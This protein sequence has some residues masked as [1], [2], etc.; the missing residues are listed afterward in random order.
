WAHPNHRYAP[1]R[2]TLEAVARAELGLSQP[3]LLQQLAPAA[4]GCATVE[5]L[6]RR[7]SGHGEERPAL[8]RL[9]GALLDAV[10]AGDQVAIEVL[11][12]VATAM[13]EFAIVAARRV[14]LPAP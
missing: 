1:V 13:A 4:T 3:S 12:D 9:P 14:G 8:T 6:V 7:A 5:E 10:Q 2:S 11:G